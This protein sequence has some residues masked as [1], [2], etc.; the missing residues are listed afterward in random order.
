MMTVFGF[1]NAII[2]IFASLPLAISDYSVS[3]S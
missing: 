3:I 2:S 1:D